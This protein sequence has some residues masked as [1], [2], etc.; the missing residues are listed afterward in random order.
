MEILALMGNITTMNGEY[1]GH[2]H[3]TLGKDDGS[4]VGGHANELHISATAEIFIQVLAGE[5]DRIREENV[6]LNVLD[7]K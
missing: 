6:G 4:C 5:V 2:M 3:V 1:Y 7:L